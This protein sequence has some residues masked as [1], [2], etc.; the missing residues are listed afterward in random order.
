MKRL[1]RVIYLIVLFFCTALFF[2]SRMGE[3][4][5]TDKTETVS[6]GETEFPTITVQTCGEE[7]NC[8]YGYSSNLAPI[9]NRENMIPVGADG[10]FELKIDEYDMTIRRLKYEILDVSSEAE[11][12][13][14]T[15]NAFDKQEDYKLVRIKLKETLKEGT[16]YAVKVTLINNVGKRM[17]YYFRIKQYEKPQLSEKLAF[18]RDFSQKTRSGE[19]A[20]MEA[21]I[22]Y[23]EMQAGAPSD[24]LGYVDIHSNYR[25]VAW[26]GLAPE[27]VTEPLVFVTEFYDEIMTAVVRYSVMINAGYGEEYYDVKEYYR[28]RYLGDVVHLLNYERRAEAIFDVKNASLSQSDLKIGITAGEGPELYPNSD[29]SIVA[30]VRNG[31]LYC[32]GMA[33]N[34]LSVVFSSTDASPERMYGRQE[35]YDIRVLKIEDGG[36]ITFLVNGYMNRG[37]YEG[38]VGLFVYRY[39]H[40]QKRLEELIYIPVNTTYQILKEELGDFAYLNEYD[41]FYFM[42]NRDLYAYNLVT[43]ELKEIASKIKDGD[44]VYSVTGRYIAYQEA[45]QTD[46]IKILY[47]ETGNIATIEPQS[48]EYIKLLAQSEENLICGYGKTEELEINEDGSVTYAMYKVQI[49]SALGQLKKVYRKEGYYVQSAET[50]GNVIRLNRLVR[51]DTGGY[52]PTE[53]DYI[54][55]Q[56]KSS[57]NKISLTKRVTERLLTEY[58]ISFP[59]NFVMEELPEKFSVLYTVVEEDTT[60]RINEM[61]A[62]NEEYYTYYYGMIDG[63][64]ESAA[65]AILAADEKV[66]TV[67]NEEGKIVWER[68]VKATSASVPSI[69][70]VRS[71]NGVNAIQAAVKM[72]LSAKGIT[73]D[74]SEAESAQPLNQVMG[75]YTKSRVV[76]LTKA[77]LD[78]VLYFVWK[79]QPVLAMKEPGGAVVITSYN[80]R[81]IVYYDP[82]RGRSVTVEKDAAEALFET[83]GGI[84]ISFLY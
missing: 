36:D 68:G 64:Y 58:Y 24:T 53:S 62:G 63:I 4:M 2:V 79:G 59:S 66:G 72:M 9:L 38:R 56:D 20:D 25:L 43:E 46:C 30:F 23:L 77:T 40:L 10:I 15:I 12:D 3:T 82:A 19:T 22:P 70:G 51:K 74:I 60:L 49:S 27:P 81:E 50:S 11:I 8:L 75:R 31:T 26:G 18:I 14:G 34:T 16:E 41:V 83:G 73:V 61:E 44:Y 54:L 35:G 80:A 29:N 13:S 37:V 21:L 52:E 69:T 76:V 28:I 7:I 17:Y 39:F 45:G 65:E 57:A 32:Y 55:N 84:F 6:M 78:E 42:V 33:D 1:Y 47:P 5:F 67:I 48:G 71:E